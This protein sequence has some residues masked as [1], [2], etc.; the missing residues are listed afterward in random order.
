MNA[1]DRFKW[2]LLAVAAFPCLV[3][4]AA[5]NFWSG[6]GNWTNSVRWSRGYVPVA[7]ESVSISGAVMLS[8][9]T[10]ALAH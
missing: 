4:A 2:M 8:A 3:G 9:S 10:A 1:L 6:S 5:T 7:G